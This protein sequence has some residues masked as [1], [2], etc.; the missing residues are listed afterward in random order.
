MKKCEPLTEF[1][2]I[3]RYFSDIGTTV[4]AFTF[5][6]ENPTDYNTSQKSRLIKGVGDDCALLSLAE[7]QHLALSIDTLVA[8]RHFPI[9]ANPY[10]LAQRALAVSVSDLAAMG[11]TPLAFTLALTLPKIDN[12]WLQGFS[13]GLRR[14]A[15]EYTIALIGGDTTQ[16]PLALSVQVH[17]SV[18]KQKALTRSAAKLG[19]SIF[20]SGTV[21]D[22][23]AALAVIEKNLNVDDLQR[24]YFLSRYYQPQARIKLGESLVGIANAAIDVSDGLLADLAHIAKASHL[25]AR[26]NSC[27]VPISPQLSAVVNEEQALEYALTGGDDYELCFTV[28]ADRRQQVLDISVSLGLSISEIGKMV[29]GQGVS[30]VDKQGDEISFTRLGYQHFQ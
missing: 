24:Q 21:G 17:G 4:D 9:N 29:A 2:I 7:D 6:S 1:D 28:C 23:A 14:A 18:A 10:E 12:E 27:R 15:N 11:A 5:T 22:A 25:A 3:T 26:V 8:G 16:G 20:V 13:D 19:D 30:C